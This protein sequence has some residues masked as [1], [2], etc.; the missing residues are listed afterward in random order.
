MKK[1]PMTKECHEKLKE[2]L[3][4]IKKVERPKNIR[5]IEEARA[6]GDLSENAEYHAAKERQS[7]IEGKILE[8]QGKIAHAQIID[9]SKLSGERVVFGATVK[10]RDIDSEEIKIYTLLGA[11]ETDIKNGK[12]SVQ[13]PVG[14]SLI[15]HT[16][17]DTVNI[18]TPAKDIE[19][20][21]LE[22]SFG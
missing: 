5:E 22:I 19:Y 17:G 2:E 14:K 10:L 18:K 3:S 13:S 21:I 15:G 7:F 11:E 9:T 4:Y 16:I 12:I 8:I 1:I 20:E 6:H